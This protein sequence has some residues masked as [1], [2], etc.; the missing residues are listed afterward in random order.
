MMHISF[1]AVLKINNG[2]YI[3]SNQRIMALTLLLDK[4]VD[5]IIT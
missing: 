5:H 3:Q 4:V 2:S 1:G